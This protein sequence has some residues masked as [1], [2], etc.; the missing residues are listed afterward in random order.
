MLGYL[1]SA[2]HHV[3]CK[4]ETLR[5]DVAFRLYSPVVTP[6]S[7]VEYSVNGTYRSKYRAIV[8]SKP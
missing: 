1:Q 6:V 7:P 5:Y 3:E 4:P 8:A 2:C